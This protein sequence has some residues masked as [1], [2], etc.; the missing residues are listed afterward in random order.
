MSRYD[1]Q[2]ALLQIGPERQKQLHESS[3]LVIGAGGLGSPVLYYL[4]AAGVGHIGIVDGDTV[5]E[6]NLNRQI[7][8][9]SAD[10]ALYEAKRQGK[11]RCA[12]YQEQ[13]GPGSELE[14]LNRKAHNCYII[15]QMCIRDR[16]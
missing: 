13:M 7:L 15:N 3:V 12:F 2:L 6:T 11:N 9:R 5:E 16:R 10:I 8:Y 4:A 1:R 14:I